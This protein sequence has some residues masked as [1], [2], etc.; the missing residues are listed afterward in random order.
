MEKKDVQENIVL[1]KNNYYICPV[2]T[3]LNEYNGLSTRKNK[4]G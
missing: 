3:N 1:V 4:K 2:K